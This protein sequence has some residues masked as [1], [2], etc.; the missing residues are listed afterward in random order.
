MKIQTLFV[1]VILCAL[2]GALQARSLS[3][4]VGGLPYT[5]SIK[6]AA[7]LA[8]DA[9]VRAEKPELKLAKTVTAKV[10]V[11]DVKTYTILYANSVNFFDVVAVNNP[12]A[13][14]QKISITSFATRS[15][16][17]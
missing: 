8:I 12:A 13:D 11:T 10:Q 2:A 4:K 15:R 17:A 3:H 9:Y 6:S 14:L 5:V 1:A 16:D 7:F